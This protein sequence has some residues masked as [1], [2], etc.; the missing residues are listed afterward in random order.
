MPAQAPHTVGLEIICVLEAHPSADLPVELD[1]E[2]LL[3]LQQIPLTKAAGR[4]DDSTPSIGI[5][6]KPL[7]TLFGSVTGSLADPIRR[8][9]YP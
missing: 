2:M 3:F 4:W 6:R 8:P 9:K 7:V 1:S 5:A